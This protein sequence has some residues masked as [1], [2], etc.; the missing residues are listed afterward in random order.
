M[1]ISIFQTIKPHITENKD[2]TYIQL[3][4][5]KSFKFIVTAIF[6]QRSFIILFAIIFLLNIGPR[7]IN[8]ASVLRILVI[9]Y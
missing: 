7:Y 6:L 2:S 4:V 1:E 5:N 3:I 9:G 8:Y